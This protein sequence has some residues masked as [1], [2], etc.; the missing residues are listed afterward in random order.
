[1][2]ATRRPWT[3][4]AVCVMVPALTLLVFGLS[5]VPVVELLPGYVAAYLLIGACIFGPAGKLPWLRQAVAFLLP[6]ALLVPLALLNLGFWAGGWLLGLPAW[7]LLVSRWT[8]ENPL[9]PV[10]L[11]KFWACSCWAW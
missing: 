5:Q 9:Q 10:Q 1:M 7:G 11:L 4:A 2:S 8:P 3:F 6:G